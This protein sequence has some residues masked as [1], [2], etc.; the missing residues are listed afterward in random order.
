MSKK[1]NV[2]DWDMF[3]ERDE[4]ERN[5]RLKK[6]KQKQSNKNK[7]RKENIKKPRNEKNAKKYS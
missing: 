6:K 1:I 2:R 5:R 3:H 7:K 4:R